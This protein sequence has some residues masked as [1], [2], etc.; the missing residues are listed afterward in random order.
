SSITKG[1]TPTNTFNGH[2]FRQRTLSVWAGNFQRPAS[3]TPFRLSVFHS[4]NSLLVRLS[5]PPCPLL[6]LSFEGCSASVISALKSLS[7]TKKRGSQLR[8]PL[9]T[10]P[11][12]TA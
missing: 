2:N 8:P 1:S 7:R 11:P 12:Q 4:W 5:Q 6:A 10:E 3:A 9:L